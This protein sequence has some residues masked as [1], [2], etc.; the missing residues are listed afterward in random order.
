L[1]LGVEVDG[2]YGDS[3]LTLPIGAISPQ[4][5]KLLACSKESLMHAISSIR[6]GMHFKELSQILES[7]ITERGF[8]PLKGFCGH[9]IGKK[10]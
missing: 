4:D 10:P 6:V 9:G 2:H 3:A 7:A 8:V 1:D 5:E